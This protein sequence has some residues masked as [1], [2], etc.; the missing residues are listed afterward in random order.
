[1]NGAMLRAATKAGGSWDR[2]FS[3]GSVSDQESGLEWTLRRK[4]IEGRRKQTKESGGGP[5]LGG[6]KGVDDNFSG[7]D[8]GGPENIGERGDGQK[9]TRG[10]LRGPTGE[11]GSFCQACLPKT[12]LAGR[13]D[14]L[15]R[16]AQ[17]PGNEVGGVVRRRNAGWG[18]NFSS[19]G[20][21]RKRKS[22]MHH[23]LR[24]VSPSGGRLP[25]FFMIGSPAEGWIAFRR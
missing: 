15:G 17:A 6:R 7:H 1:L 5:R 18:C 21:K 12:S 13:S 11:I 20:K 14:D 8:W 22:P 23:L 2:F 9:R 25:P 4:E 10:K 3:G 16:R 19:N 24:D